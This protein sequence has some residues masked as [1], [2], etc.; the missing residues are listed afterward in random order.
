[1]WIA[2]A[3]ALLPLLATR[4]IS[5]L[6]A[7][8]RRVEEDEAPRRDAWTLG[9]WTLLAASIVALIL[10]QAERRADRA[11]VRGG[12]AGTLGALWLSAWGVT[13][14]ARRTTFRAFGYPA[15]QGI[16]NLHRPGNQ[17]RVVVLAL[18]FGVFLLAVVYLVQSNLLRPLRVD[19]GSQGNLLLFDVQQDQ[20]A[21]VSGILSQGGTRVLQK[22]PI[23][24]MRVAAINGVSAARLA[25]RDGED[26]DSAGVPERGG[27]R[28]KGSGPPGDRD[29]PEG[30]AVR[31]EYRSTYRDSLVDSEVVLRGRMWAPGQGGAG[32]DG[33]AQVSMDVSVAEDLKVDVGDVDHLGRAG[34]AHPHPR[35][36]HPR[37]GLAAAGAQLLRRFSHG[38]A[39]GRPADVGDAG[40]GAGRR[41]ARRGPA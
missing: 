4:S 22:A 34:R 15:R 30:W 20:E 24:P 16:A 19:A 14:A 25:P 41:R 33:L 10:F 11:G 31:R 13:K 17:T 28:Q 37:G 5:P 21:G 8:R 36:L 27:T 6:Q 3:F 40:Q 1:M 38:G 32:R 7:I 35:H 9:G 26:A 23:I 12:V 29:A 18:G 39:A 2:A